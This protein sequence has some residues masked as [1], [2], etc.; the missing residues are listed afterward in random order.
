MSTELMLDPNVSAI[1]KMDITKKD[2]IEMIEVD[3]L[4]KIRS[5]MKRIESSINDIHQEYGLSYWPAMEALD[6]KEKERILKEFLLKFKPLKIGKIFSS[7]IRTSW[8]MKN[9]ER[10]FEREHITFKNTQFG[11][12][13]ERPIGIKI[14]CDLTTKY[15]QATINIPVNKAYLKESLKEHDR[16]IEAIK[17]VKVLIQEYEDLERIEKGLPG[18]LKE[19][20]AA[21]SKKALKSSNK[22]KELLKLLEEIQ[23]SLKI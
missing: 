17:K 10:Y 3:T 4:G 8:I 23:V 15:V 16:K 9:N 14:Q 19:F 11:F 12:C 5:Q 6:K 7:F 20:S 13:P 21:L 1:T 22:G 2:L 18:K